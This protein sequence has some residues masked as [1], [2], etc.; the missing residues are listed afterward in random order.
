[1]AVEITDEENLSKTFEFLKLDM[2]F[3]GTDINGD[4]VIYKMTGD[5]FVEEMK[6]VPKNERKDNKKDAS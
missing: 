6:R 4:Y 5:G 1:M 3:T 2:M